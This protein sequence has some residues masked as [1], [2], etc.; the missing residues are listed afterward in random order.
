MN[1]YVVITEDLTPSGILV[2]DMV[3]IEQ[4]QGTRPDWDTEGKTESVAIGHVIYWQ[5]RVSEFVENHYDGATGY[6]DAQGNKK[7]I[8]RYWQAVYPAG[9]RDFFSI[10]LPLATEP[11]DTLDW[12]QPYVKNAP[13]KP[14]FSNAALCRFLRKLT[15]VF[16][17]SVVSVMPTV[18]FADA[19]QLVEGGYALGFWVYGKQLTVSVDSSPTPQWYAINNPENGE[20]IRMEMKAFQIHPEYPEHSAFALWFA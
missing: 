1:K 16:M 10:V 9:E 13:L 2:G 11:V 5:Y 8:P 12:V 4:V 20:S 17:Q 3:T 6:I 14:K 18:R 7:H 15:M 19:V